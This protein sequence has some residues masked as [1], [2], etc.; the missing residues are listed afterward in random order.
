MKE[1]YGKMTTSHKEK[2]CFDQW[3][4]GEKF[5]VIAKNLRVAEATTEVY[6]ID[7]VCEGYATPTERRRLLRDMGVDD[8]KFKEI[9]GHLEKG[10]V[11]LREIKDA[12]T[13]RYNQI[14][15]VIGYLIQESN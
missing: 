4:A 3:R 10:V 9:L 14:R 11:L 8:N 2:T 13:F 15:A 7:M 6:T 1:I 5:S 12:T